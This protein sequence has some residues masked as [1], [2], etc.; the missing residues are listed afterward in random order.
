[1][2]KACV[3]ASGHQFPAWLLHVLYERPHR[4]DF[5]ILK[6]KYFIDNNREKFMSIPN[7]E[8]SVTSSR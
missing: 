2:D 5:I 3:W 4:I 1:M 6:V 8:N 7:S